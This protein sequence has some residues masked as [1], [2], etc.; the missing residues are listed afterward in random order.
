VTAY[1]VCV[2]SKPAGYEVVV[3]RS[4]AQLSE[5]YKDAVAVCPYGKKVLGAGGA[6]SNTAPGNVSL[7]MIHI[8]P[9]QASVAAIENTPTDLN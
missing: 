1:A 7:F 2:S 6:I 3:D 5:T 4:S 9:W 8:Y